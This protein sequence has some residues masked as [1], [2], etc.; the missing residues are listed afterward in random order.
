MTT[1]SQPIPLDD[2]SHA[3]ILLQTLIANAEEAR[4]HE[5]LANTSASSVKWVS[6][7]QFK[8]MTG[9]NPTRR[10]ECGEWPINIMWRKLGDSRNA[11]IVIN[12]EAFNLWVEKGTQAFEQARAGKASM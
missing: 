9:I 4:R 1:S 12:L 11:R 3:I 5:M 10:I 2:V 7:E 8:N 6:K